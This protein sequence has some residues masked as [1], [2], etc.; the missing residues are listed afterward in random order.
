MIGFSF[1]GRHCSEFGIVMQSRNRQ[2]IPEKTDEYVLPLGKDGSV[3]FPGG[4]ADRYIELGCIVIEKNL[5]D[6]RSKTRE[7][8]AW[9][10]TVSRGK[11]EFDDEPGIYYCGKIS[12]VVD[13][14]ETRTTNSF[15]LVFRC[16][17]LVYGAEQVVNFINDTVTVNNIGTYKTFPVFDLDFMTTSSEIKIS[18]GTDYIRVVH[19]FK[20]G[21]KLHVADGKVLIN[22][23]RALEKLD[24]QNSRFL[25]LTVGE[26]VLNIT[27]LGKC[28]AVVKYIPRWL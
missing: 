26:N 25:D 13:L 3:L 28:T 5:T 1:N 24:W 22:G 7:I 14:N 15:N 6:M 21:D 18:K 27:P 10:H 23:V 12:E 16:E 9:L 4:F 19:A 20:A 11:L 2:L 8:A 17:P